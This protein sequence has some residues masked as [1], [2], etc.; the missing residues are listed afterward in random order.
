MG[1]EGQRQEHRPVQERIVCFF[2]GL[3]Q[4]HGGRETLAHCRGSVE[5]G[6]SAGCTGIWARRKHFGVLETEL[7][8]NSSLGIL[9]SYSG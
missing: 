5:K 8:Q 2:H 3:E 9:L 6:I 4:T 7:G 1:G